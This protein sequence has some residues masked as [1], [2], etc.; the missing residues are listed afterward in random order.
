MR[1]GTP[2]MHVTDHRHREQAPTGDWRLDR[3]HAPAWE[4]RQG[5]SAFRFWQVT[6]SVT[7]C[8]P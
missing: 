7:G 2:D 4:C 3:S 1:P 5:R 8:I 6:Q